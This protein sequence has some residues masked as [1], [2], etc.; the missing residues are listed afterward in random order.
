[1]EPFSRWTWKAFA[2]DPGVVE[3]GPLGVL[4]FRS[5]KAVPIHQP[6]QHL[7]PETLPADPPRRLNYRVRFVGSEVGAPN[8]RTFVD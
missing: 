2:P 5:A 1:M 7:V 4:G 3:V 8:M 6:Q